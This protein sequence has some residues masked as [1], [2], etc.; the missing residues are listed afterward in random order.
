MSDID[1]VQ[2]TLQ[3]K[4]IMNKANQHSRNLGPLILFCC[5]IVIGVAGLAGVNPTSELASVWN[6]TTSQVAHKDQY[7]SETISLRV[8]GVANARNIPTGEGSTVVGQFQPGDI[9][10]GRWVEGVDPSVRWFK[11]SNGDYIW[12][13]NLA[14]PYQ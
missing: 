5:L 10:H 2:A 7:L 12:G 3:P 8:T 1:S 9:L 6:S 14:D 11:T 13:G 4:L